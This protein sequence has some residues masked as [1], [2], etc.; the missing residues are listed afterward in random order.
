M[1]SQIEKASE[2]G[3]LDEL[4]SDLAQW[5]EELER[6]Q[7]LLPLEAQYSAIKEKE[8]PELEKQ[9]KEEKDRLPSYVSQ[10]E[11]VSYKKSSGVRSRTDEYRFPRNSSKATRLSGISTH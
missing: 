2:K 10:Y 3:K 8:L 7:K 11:L 4:K 1:R 9:V 5:K 6:F